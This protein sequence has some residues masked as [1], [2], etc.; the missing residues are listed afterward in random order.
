MSALKSGRPRRRVLGHMTRAALEGAVSYGTSV[1]G[2][3]NG[4]LSTLRS[5]AGKLQDHHPDGR[6]RTLALMI[7]PNTDL[8]PIYRVTWQ[9]IKFLMQCWWEQWL[10]QSA[11]ATAMKATADH[12][13]TLNTPWAAIRGPFSAAWATLWRIGVR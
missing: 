5:L 4:E 6:S 12:L 11:M 2:M 10:P 9:P 7:A 3:N 13:V 1:L 8:D